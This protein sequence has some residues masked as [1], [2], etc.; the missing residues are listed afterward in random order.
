MT[1]KMLNLYTVIA[2]LAT[3][4]YTWLFRTKPQTSILSL[5]L[6]VLAII[7]EKAT[8]LDHV[9]SPSANLVCHQFQRATDKHRY[10]QYLKKMTAKLPQGEWPNGIHHVLEKQKREIKLLEH[11]LLLDDKIRNATIQRCFDV[12]RREVN[13]SDDIRELFLREEALNR[14]NAEI[15]EVKIQESFGVNIEKSDFKDPKS[16]HCSHCNITRFPRKILTKR[17]YRNYW[18]QLEH[19]YLGYNWIQNIPPEI[20]RLKNLK[21]F[22]FNNNQLLNIP[23]EIGQLEMLVTLDLCNN[24][25]QDIP[26]EI[27]QLKNLT[28]LYLKSNNL[29]ILPIEIFLLRNLGWLNLSNNEIQFLPNEIGE[30]NKLHS[31]DLRNN[32]LQR[33]PNNLR[34]N[35]LIDFEHYKKITENKVLALQERPGAQVNE[36]VRKPS[37]Q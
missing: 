3:R 34:K 24:N 28:Y 6:D 8:P 33:L 4:V 37:L 15:F 22:R 35:I 1:R 31:L 12:L 25:L 29:Q 5:P 26:P 14:I 19:L 17:K 21:T 36:K 11:A 18:T 23:P 32:Y 7:I 20:T 10:E 13:E 30:M 27:G 2:K 16:L 9:F